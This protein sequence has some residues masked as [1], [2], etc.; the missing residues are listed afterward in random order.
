MKTIKNKVKLNTELLLE[1]LVTVDD[2]NEPIKNGVWVYQSTEDELITEWYKTMGDAVRAA[3]E[4][5]YAI[6][7]SNGKEVQYDI[8]D[9]NR[10]YYIDGD[11]AKIVNL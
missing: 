2:N 1:K 11:V 8:I 9:S 3:I 7:I 6:I 4:F 5:N 10:A